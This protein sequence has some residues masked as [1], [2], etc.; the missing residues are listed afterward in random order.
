[1]IQIKDEH[2]D[3]NLYIKLDRYLL[4]SIDS[5]FTNALHVEL[6]SRLWGRLYIQLV[7]QLHQTQK[8]VNK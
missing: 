1:M 4:S 3:E 2:F 8:V 6:K 5:Q 7:K